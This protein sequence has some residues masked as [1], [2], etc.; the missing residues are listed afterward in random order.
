MH[1]LNLYLGKLK[2]ALIKR[3]YN[4]FRHVESLLPHPLMGFTQYISWRESTNWLLLQNYWRI[5]Q[6][7]V[8]NFL[9]NI[10]NFLSKQF[11]CRGSPYRQD[12][13]SKHRLFSTHFWPM[14]PF[15][16]PSKQ[17]KTIGFPVFSAGVNWE[18]LAKNR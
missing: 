2:N 3:N 9:W 5:N 12:Q 14:F 18:N 17:Q 8:C 15:Y 1:S 11:F 16:T 6:G 4:M 10:F 13:V 7:I